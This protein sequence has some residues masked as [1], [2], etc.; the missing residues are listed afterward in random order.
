[1]NSDE[2]EGADKNKALKEKAVRRMQKEVDSSSEES[3]NDIEN[4]EEDS[5]DGQIIM[6]FDEKSKQ[7]SKNEGKKTEKGIMGLKFMERAQ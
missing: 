5:D 3:E 2:E 6:K 4:S 1:M 7:R